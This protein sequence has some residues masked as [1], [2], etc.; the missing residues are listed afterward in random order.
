M[1]ANG[2]VRA[3]AEPLPSPASASSRRSAT[4]ATRSATRCSR[5]APASR[6]SPRFDI[7][8]LPLDAG[9]AGAPASTP[10]Q[11]VAP[12]KLRRMDDDRP[13]SRSSPCSRRWTR[14]GYAATTDG[15]DR[16]GVVL[17][18]YSAGGQATNE[19]LDALFTRRPGRRA[20]AALQ[21]HRRQRRRGPGRPRVQ[22]ARA[23]R[24][25]QPQGSVGPRRDRHRGRPAAR[26][27]R[28]TPSS[29]AASTR[30]TRPSSRRTIASRV[31]TPTPRSP[32]A[33][34]R[35]STPIA[36]RLRAGR[37]R[38]RAVARADDGWRRAAPR[39]RRDPRRRRRERGGAA[40]RLARRARSR[41]SA[42]CAL[43]LDDAGLVAGGRR[44]GLCLGERDRT[45]R[46][47]RGTRARRR[48]SAARAP[49]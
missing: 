6:R 7:C 48:S 8:G 20:G 13:V 42:R 41:S 12:M 47:G 44:R 31:M 37:R 14:R 9:G 27:P 11:W 34:S 40:E 15:D 4:R 10:A 36:A 16:A 18:T 32:T 49:S 3:V 2:N 24:D 22:A 43:A 46:R 19:Y 5:A 21:Q 17:G 45:P 30:S 35:R 39:P 29:P 33:P 23:E 25:G 1:I 26:R 28:A 38:L